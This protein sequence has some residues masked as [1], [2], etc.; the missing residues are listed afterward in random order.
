VFFLLQF[1]ESLNTL[2]HLFFHFS[3]LILV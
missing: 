2:T 3:K 1:P